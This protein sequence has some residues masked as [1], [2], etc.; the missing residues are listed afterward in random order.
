MWVFHLCSSSPFLLFAAPFCG[1]VGLV[2]ARWGQKLDNQVVV[3]KVVAVL[4]PEELVPGTSSLLGVCCGC[5]AIS[6]SELGAAVLS[7]VIKIYSMLA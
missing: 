6:L 2:M 1:L 7:T 5:A 4:V 3:C